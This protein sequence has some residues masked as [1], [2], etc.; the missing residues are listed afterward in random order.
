MRF[1]PRAALLTV[2]VLAGCNMDVTNPG[3]IDTSR[4]DPSQDAAL[5]SLSAQSNLHRAVGALNVY[6]GLVAQEVWVGAIR[7][8]TNEIGRRV[9][10]AG[11]SDINS[12]IWTPLQRAIGT[13]ELTVQTL[14]KSPGAASDINLARAYMNAG[15]SLELMAEAFCQGAILVGPPLTPAQVSDTA[16]ARFQQ[17]ITIG[18]AAGGAEGTKVVNASNVGLA[19]AYLQKKDYPNA[20]IAAAKVPNAF[21]YDALA[22]DDPANRGLAN[23]VYSYD[24]SSR[25]LVVPPVYRGYDDPRV[26][27]KDAGPNVNAQDTQLHYYQQLKFPGWSSPIRIASTMEAQYILAEAKLLGQPSDPTVALALIADRRTANGQGVFAGVTNA[28]ILAELMDQ[29]AREFWLEGKRLGDIIR[30]PTAI[31]NVPAPGDNYYKPAMGKY[32]NLTCFPVPMAEIL[33][34]PNFPKS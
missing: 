8:E 22:V 6:T 16:I 2:A 24:G 12:G 3:V 31:A 17:A 14:A 25:L 32:G 4:F 5:L 13:N 28:E 9:A 20:A 33:A 1:A 21:T 18:A 30:N 7:A 10:T 15:F 29:R 34:N 11:I 27:W 26:K 23:G 19:R